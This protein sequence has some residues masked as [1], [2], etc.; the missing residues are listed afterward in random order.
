M[1]LLLLALH[2]VLPSINMSSDN[3]FGEMDP[4][5]IEAF[6][7]LESMKAPDWL[8]RT[9]PQVSRIDDMKLGK[10]KQAFSLVYSLQAAQSRSESVI[11]QMCSQCQQRT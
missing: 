5:L 3:E 10:L 11:Q 8:D 6:D 7:L 9:S 2:H 4:E 1:S